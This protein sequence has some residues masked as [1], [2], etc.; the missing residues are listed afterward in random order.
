MGKTVLRIRTTF[1]DKKDAQYLKN[2]QNNVII[3]VIKLSP[4]L[5]ISTKCF[6]MVLQKLIVKMAKKKIS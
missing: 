2:S 1:K 6:S 3:I 4:R 5:T